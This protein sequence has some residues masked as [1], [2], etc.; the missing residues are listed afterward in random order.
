MLSKSKKLPA[1][2]EQ[3]N[4]RVGQDGARRGQRRCG[5]RRPRRRPAGDVEQAVSW[6]AQ[7]KEKTDALL[8]SLNM[9]A[10]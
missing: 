9:T 8:A 4:A 10:G 6:R 3:G 1:G 7:V 5:R 2:V